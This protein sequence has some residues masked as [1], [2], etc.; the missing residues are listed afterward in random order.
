MQKEVRN[1]AVSMAKGVAIILMVMGHAQC[2]LW[3]W[4]YIYMFHMPLFFFFSGYCF[5]TSYLDDPRS[6][7]KKRF[8]GIYWPYVKWNLVFLLLHNIFFFLNIYNDEFGFRG[9]VSH[10]YDAEEY[11][12]RFLSII[13]QMKGEEQLLGGYWFL[14]SLFFASFI[15][16]LILLL[17]IKMKVSTLLGALLMPLTMVI[18]YTGKSLPY[19]G[20]GAKETLASF[21][22]LTGFWYKRSGFHFE[23]YK[24]WLMIPICA[25]FVA[26]GTEFWQCDMFSITQITILPYMLTA[27]VGILMVFQFCRISLLWHRLR[28]SFMFVGNNTL[29]ILTWH[30]LSFKI[31]SL[32]II[33]IY[34]LP[35]RRLAEFPVIDEYACQG[36]WC[37]YMIIGISLPI[38]FLFSIYNIREKWNY[39]MLLKRV[40]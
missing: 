40:K 26:V 8:I 16:Y 12:S 37:G 27:L 10:L 1:D 18:L 39:D 3:L 17:C 30:F 36:W 4:S 15:F 23:N 6:F 33:W 13:T 14:H 28:K 20:V 5:K 24:P 11:V 22:M 34:S 32:L 21:F 19:F 25:L 7:A 35:I 29:L 2:P 31:V 38:L 9:E